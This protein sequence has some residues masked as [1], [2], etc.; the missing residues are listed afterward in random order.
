[1]S[2]LQQARDSASGVKML[3]LAERM[4]QKGLDKKAPEVA[5]SFDELALYLTLLQDQGKVGGGGG[6]G[7]GW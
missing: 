6:G 2:M 4:V 1:V 3:E 7:G 5:P